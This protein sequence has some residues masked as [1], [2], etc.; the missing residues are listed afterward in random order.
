MVLLALPC[1]YGQSPPPNDSEQPAATLPVPEQNPPDVETLFPHL[2][3][4]R[5]W[6]SGQAN[7]IF[8]THPPFTAPYSG[9]QQPAAQLRKGAFP[10][11]DALYRRSLE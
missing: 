10:R 3:D 4:T 9:P 2:A 7:F 8:Q 5:Y 1:A 11:A 6:L